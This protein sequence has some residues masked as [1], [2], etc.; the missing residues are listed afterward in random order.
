MM[1]LFLMKIFKQRPFFSRFIIKYK[2]GMPR[3]ED[4]AAT[5]IYRL[6]GYKFLR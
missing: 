3:S 6:I 2:V 4:T 1:G 5:L